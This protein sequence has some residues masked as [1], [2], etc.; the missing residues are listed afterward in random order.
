MANVWFLYFTP[1]VTDHEGSI[2]FRQSKIK[3]TFHTWVRDDGPTT[4]G[5]PDISDRKTF[6]IRDL[7]VYCDPKYVILLGNL[8]GQ[9]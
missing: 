7:I 9:T 1:V 6:T 3:S 5:P 8:D 4:S 2:T